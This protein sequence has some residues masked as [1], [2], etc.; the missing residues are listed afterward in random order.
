VTRTVLSCTAA[1]L[2]GFYFVRKFFPTLD[3]PKDTG[4]ELPGLPY[5]PPD[6]AVNPVDY[7]EL[8]L[9]IQ[10]RVFDSN[11]ELWYPQV[12]GVVSEF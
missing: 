6:G 1:G 10:D 3:L 5:P 9:A 12:Q 11:G 7:L 2:A 4:P 8:P